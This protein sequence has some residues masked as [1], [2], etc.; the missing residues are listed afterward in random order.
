LLGEV[1]RGRY[2]EAVARGAA[3]AERGG[4][5]RPQRA[6]IYRALTEAYAALEARGLATD[7]C[8]AWRRAEDDSGDMWLMTFSDMVTLLLS[9]FIV[10]AAMSSLSATP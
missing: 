4:L 5:S 9:F 10:L 3:L 7:A 1:R 2:V 6:Q 8:G